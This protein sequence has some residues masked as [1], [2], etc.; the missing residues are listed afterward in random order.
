MDERFLR[1][2]SIVQE[3]A[4]ARGGVFFLDCGEGH[5]LITDEID[6]EDLSGWLIKE[7]DIAEFEPLWFARRFSEL[8]DKFD[9]DMV[10][11]RWSGTGPDDI[12]VDF[13]F[14][15]SWMLEQNR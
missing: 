14:Y 7:A 4:A 8:P 13:D 6:C 10:V 5:D 11:A 1:F 9:T 15:N 12:E 3:V 2:F